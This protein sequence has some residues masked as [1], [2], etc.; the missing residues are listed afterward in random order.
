MIRNA[1]KNLIG[2]LLLSGLVLGSSAAVR[3]GP[4][5]SSDIQSD[6][7][8]AYQQAYNYILTEKWDEAEKSFSAFL[9]NFPESRWSDDARYWQ[10][11]LLE[12]KGASQE[13]AFKCY[14]SFVD[15]NPSSE[16]AD[17]ARANMI[18]I[19]RALA[20]AGRGEYATLIEDMQK[21]ENEEVALAALYALAER[22]DANSR[23][24]IVS[25]Y[26]GSASR[27]VRAE[28]THILADDGSPQ[29]LAKLKD[30]VLKDPDE[31]I[32]RDAVEALGESRDSSDFLRQI[33]ASPRDRETQE[34]AIRVLAELNDPQAI[35]IIKK[36]V[37]GLD[38]ADERQVDLARE[39]VEALS[40]MKGPDSLAALSQIFKESK[41]TEIRKTALEGL[42]E[43]RDGLSLAALR[44]LAMNDADAEI[45]ERAMEFIAERGG[46]E[47]FGVLKEIFEASKDED[48]RRSALNGIAEMGGVPAVDFL[49][50][51]AMNSVD[52]ETASE[53][54][55][56]LGDVEKADKEK[57]YL[58]I[59]RKAKSVEAR[60]EAISELVDDKKEN[61]L[62]FVRALLKDE[63][64][65]VL[66]EAAVESLG[67]IKTD[68]VVAILLNAAKNDRDL[69]VRTAAVASLGEI[70][71][72]KAREALMEILK[73][74]N[75]NGAL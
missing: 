8:K 15:D 57:L 52:D 60:R 4:S 51:V 62:E 66:R 73:K 19:G 55:S 67:E 9:K 14:K 70:G 17:D 40:E 53:A 44:D 2:I 48:G 20:N 69:S 71:T 6:D 12:K 1:V 31:E 72:P 36:L 26:D 61:G 33:A 18:R 56:A 54:V 7:A 47:A 30:I 74:K 25:L 59:Y 29:A 65:P 63:P 39:A 43:R 28:I 41:T 3:T 34:A 11:Y 42:A 23:D 46:P 50:S 24:S 27:R 5:P 10:C 37:A 64:D 45:R 32:R 75:S 21:D 16:W 22:G 68:A 38:P 49:S 35:S 58:D 13:A